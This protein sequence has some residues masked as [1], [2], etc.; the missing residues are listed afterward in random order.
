MVGGTFKRPAGAAPLLGMN[1]GS[2]NYGDA[3]YQAQL[4][5]LDVVILGFHYKWGGDTGDGAVIRRTVQELKA[6]NP[7]LKVGQYTIMNEAKPD[8][9]SN[10]AS[11]DKAI[12]LNAMNWWLK[13]ADGTMT[14]WTTEYGAYETNFSEWAQKDANGDRYPQWL[15]KREHRLFF[16]PVPE[17]DLWYFDNVMKHSRAPAANWRY[18]GVNVSGTDPTIAAR[19]GAARLPSGKQPRRWR[20]TCCRWATPTAI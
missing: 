19:S 2:K 18:D 17:F 16:K 4:A 20:R 1:I 10:S 11:A 14:Q 3:A 15:A 5:R 6:R 9:S 8:T 7:A 12:K 13:T